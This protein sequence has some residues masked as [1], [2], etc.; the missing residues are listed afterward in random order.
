MKVCIFEDETYANFYPLS[1]TRPVFELKCGYFTLRERIQ[2]HLG[3]D[4]VC[5]FMRDYLASWFERYYGLPVNKMDSLMGD[6]VLFVNGRWLMQKDELKLEGEEEAGFFNDTLLYLRARKKTLQDIYSDDLNLREILTGLAENTKSKKIK[7][8]LINY[9]WDLINN[10]AS[11]MEKDF[12]LLGRVGI[13]GT[14]PSGSFIEG[15]SDKIFIASSAEIEPLV[16]L[17]TKSGPIFIDEGAKV[18]S[19]TRIEGPCY[20][21]RNSQAK[22]NIREGTYIGPVCRVGGGEIEE[23]IIHGFTNKYHEGFIGHSYLGEWVNIGA[24]TTTSDLKND[25]TSVQVYINGELR[26]SGQTKVG[27]FI[28]DHSKTGIGTLLNTGCVI[29]VGSNV[30]AGG[31]VTP[32]HIPSFC[33]YLNQKFYKGSGLKGIINTAKVVMERRGVRLSSEQERIL[34]E[35]FK[36]T[37]GERKEMIA[38]SRR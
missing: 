22:G 16:V 28:G 14:F 15:D 37:D 31:G 10:N 18:L 38:R 17:S 36:I 29:G 8:T 7:V 2:T 35:V 3:T 4:K 27:S 20:I 5:Y 1:L 30:V 33:W 6:D 13:K 19:L 21:G 24:L 23:T 34:E 32:K 11:Q 26:D 12:I 9:L 25:Y